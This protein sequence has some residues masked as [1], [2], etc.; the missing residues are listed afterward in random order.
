MEFGSIS[1]RLINPTSRNKYGSNNV[2]DDSGNISTLIN[3][4]EVCILL[5]TTYMMNA[6]DTHALKKTWNTFNLA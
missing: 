4:R 5:H 2:S 1:G 3:F 6:F